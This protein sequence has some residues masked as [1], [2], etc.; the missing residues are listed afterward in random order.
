MKYLFSLH[1]NTLVTKTELPPLPQYFRN[2]IQGNAQQGK[3][4]KTEKYHFHSSPLPCPVA[5]R[6]VLQ[7]KI[8]GRWHVVTEGLKPDNQKILMLSFQPLSSGTSFLR[9]LP[10]ISLRKHR[11]EVHNAIL[12]PKLKRRFQ[13]SSAVPRSIAGCFAQQIQGECPQ[14]EGVNTSKSTI[15]DSAFIGRRRRKGDGGKRARTVRAERVPQSPTARPQRQAHKLDN[16]G[17]AS[18]FVLLAAEKNE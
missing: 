8:Q 11:G 5:L 18:W 13:Y 6:G 1:G 16:C 17:G 9:S 3:R 4:V 12:I 14:G 15:P 2:N 7:R 10:Y